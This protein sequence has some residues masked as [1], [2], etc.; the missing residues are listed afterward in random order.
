MNAEKNLPLFVSDWYEKYHDLLLQFSLRLGVD[1]ADAEDIINQLF[2]ELFEKKTT[3]TV[4]DNPRSYL[5]RALK[6]RIIDRY[7]K[8]RPTLFVVTDELLQQYQGDSEESLVQEEHNTEFAR[9][10]RKVYQSLPKRMQEM[11]YLKYYKGLSTEEIAQAAGITSRT[12]YNSLFEAIKLLR[13]QL[14]K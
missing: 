8:S 7:R 3:L 1:R 5:L 10:L 9:R 6:N 13:K 4:I 2:L 14:K 11:I 12:V